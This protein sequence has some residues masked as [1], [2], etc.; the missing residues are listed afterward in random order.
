M[1]RYHR[2]CFAISLT[3]GQGTGSARS[4]PGIDVGRLVLE[5]REAGLVVKG[6]GHPMAAGVTLKEERLADFEAFLVERATTGE[7]PGPSPLEIEAL[8]SPAGVSLDLAEKLSALE[9]YGAGNPEPILAVRD[10]RIMRP[11]EVGT[12]HVSCLIGGPAGGSVKAIAF[13]AMQK[14]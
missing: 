13:R 11:R 9:P 7:A 2:P 12:G 10:A 14:A 5:A 1:E 3:D 4:V 6:G 8:V